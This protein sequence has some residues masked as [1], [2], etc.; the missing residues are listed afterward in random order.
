VS[1]SAQ[2]EGAVTATMTISTPSALL[3]RILIMVVPYDHNPI[4]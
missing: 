2:T 1:G 4:E 3:I